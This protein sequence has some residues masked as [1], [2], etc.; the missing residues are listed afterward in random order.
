MYQILWI[1]II[2]KMKNLVIKEL[3]APKV[4]DN[5]TKSKKI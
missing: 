3:E 1:K 5:N 4:K 2:N